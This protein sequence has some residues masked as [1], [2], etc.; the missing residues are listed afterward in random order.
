MSLDFHCCVIFTCVNKK[1]S[2]Y[3]KGRPLRKIWGRF[4]FCTYA[5]P[6]IHCL[7]FNNAPKN[8]TTVEIHLYLS[9]Y[10]WLTFLENKTSLSTKT[11]NIRLLLYL[12]LWTKNEIDQFFNSCPA[13]DRCSKFPNRRSL[14]LGILISN[15]Y[16]SVY[17]I[18][19]KTVS[20][21]KMVY[22]LWARLSIAAS[23]TGVIILAESC[24]GGFENSFYRLH[25]S[26]SYFNYCLTLNLPLGK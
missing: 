2:V 21:A 25:Y 6:S 4:N 11:V 19:C 14:K 15:C 18:K 10:S 24:F 22:S 5:R 13:L 17:Y 26:K 16:D 1:K 8:Y 12:N 7:Y 3:L 20:V 23:L 9:D